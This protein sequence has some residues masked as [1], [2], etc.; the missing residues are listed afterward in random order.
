MGYKKVYSKGKKG[1][2]PGPAWKWDDRKQKWWSHGFDITLA[3]D[4]RKRE[5]G[6]FTQADAL[7]AIAQIR[8][9]EKEKRYGF[10]PGPAPPL[11]SDLIHSRLPD[12]KNPNERVRSERVLNDFLKI[13]EIALRLP[14]NKNLNERERVERVLHEYQK[15]AE[16]KE[17]KK[18]VE[19]LTTS[20]LR[21]FVAKR[22]VDGV[23]PQSI[24]RELNIISATMHAADTY[25]PQLAQWKTPKIPR[26][27]VSK[28]RR[29]RIFTDE[30]RKSLVEYLLA[31]KMKGERGHQPEGRYRIG[32]KL[33]FALS[34]GLRHGELNRIRKT[35]INWSQRSLKIVGTKTEYVNNP[36][37]YIRPLTDL[38]LEILREFCARSKTEFVFTRSGNE[39]PKFYKI[40]KRACEA[41]G[42]VYGRDVEGGLVFYDA[43]HDVTTRLL[44]AGVT[45]ATV[46]EQ[47]G[48][49]NR[50][51][52][53]YYSHSTPTSRAHAAE[54]REAF[55]RIGTEKEVPELTEEIIATLSELVASG[56][57][58]ALSLAKII[59]GEE[60]IPAEL[61]EE[62]M[63]GVV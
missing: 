45:P 9:A 63:V 31:P 40:F 21:L 6:F 53:L 14:S 22:V 62:L 49:A 47:M 23:Q 32:R 13:V 42:I 29:E 11:L 26:P 58:S 48:W 1:R 3:D 57:L 55:S 56:R 54:V 10:G 43:R 27:K 4:R 17:P 2:C 5:S 46:Q 38:E 52:V 24:N 20:D 61:L 41:C 28:K 7:A 59:R 12:I 35:D 60:N 37:R 33:Q 39:T 36:T 19:D 30:E 51:M 15:I 34:V 18:T 16:I 8:L 50:T 25:F 44:E